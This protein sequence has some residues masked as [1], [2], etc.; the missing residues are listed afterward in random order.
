M[1]SKD[2]IH[3]PVKIA[4]SKSGWQITADPYVISYGERFL[5]VDLGA[6]GQVIGAIQGDRLIA[7]EI[8]ELKGRSV[9]AELEQA[10]G[11][12][13]L[14]KL[15]LAQVDPERELYLAVTLEAYEDLFQEPIGQLVLRDLPL[16]LI[17]V[18]I[19]SREVSQWIL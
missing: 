5:F 11:Q 9:M 16:K 15:L 7:V 19:E 13:M 14:Y 10:I 8:K 18:D 2:N 1:P 3:E 4:L 12:Y 6:N 17:V